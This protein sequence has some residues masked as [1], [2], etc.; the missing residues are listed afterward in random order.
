[1]LGFTLVAAGALPLLQ[2][3]FMWLLTGV[4]GPSAELAR[5]NLARHRRRNTT[6]AL[7]FILSVSLVIFVASLVVLFSRMSM[8][9]VEHFNGAD[10]RLESDA[11]GAQG[12]KTELAGVKGVE[13]VSEVRWLRSRTERGT[14][15]DVV[16]SDL[17]GMKS[18]WLVPFGVDAELPR[19]L[20]TNQ[21][22][23][24]D[25]GLDGLLRVANYQ[26]AA[27]GAGS[28]NE[29]PPVVLSL[30]AA[31]FLDVRAG[32]V[33][34]LAFH[35]GPDRRTGRFQVAA[36]CETLAGFDNFR[37][38]VANAIGSGMLMPMSSFRDLTS[39]APDEARIV[40]YFLKVVGGNAAQKA[41][42]TE[43]RERFDLRFRFGVRSAAEQK[44][45]AQVMYWTTQVFFGLL[46]AVAVVI[47]V[48]ALIASMAT[49]V[50][51]R[52]WEIGMLRALGP[53]RSQL[54]RM[55]LGEALGLTLSAGVAGGAIGFALAWLF[56]LEAGSLAEVPVVFTMPYVTFLATFAISVAAGA[57]AAHLPTRRLLR[58]SPAEI[59]RQRG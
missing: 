52:R 59:L 23:Y 29:T 22:R 54:F 33:V 7:M 1:L 57:V 15:Y 12:L 50:I 10:L 37:S 21:V 8:V 47:S 27:G 40:R 25:G 58:Q 4:L 32:D 56:V 48:F 44:R 14:A 17:V 34:Q 19:V 31:R 38:R 18:L 28:T 55:F 9:M 53:R 45:D 3:L 13:R 11:T 41:A 42:A 16:L 51:E 24:A 20:Y 43:I 5:R 30:A 46:L 36:I 49:A 2:G 6:T 39:D 26:P 35:L